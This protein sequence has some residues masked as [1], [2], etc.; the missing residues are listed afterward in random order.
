MLFLPF[1]LFLKKSLEYFHAQKPDRHITGQEL[2]R[3]LNCMVVKISDSEFK[4]LMRIL[5]PGCTGCVDVSK[6]VGLIEENPKVSFATTSHLLSF[7]GR[8]LQCC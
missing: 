4:E 2:Q 3:I 1:F 7:Y 5:D 8:K 6:L